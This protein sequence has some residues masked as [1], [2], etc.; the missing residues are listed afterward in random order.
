[1]L[2]LIDVVVVV[3]EITGRLKLE[4]QSVLLPVVATSMVGKLLTRVRG[5]GCFLNRQNASYDRMNVLY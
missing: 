1:M 4:R 2:V 5:I 3:D